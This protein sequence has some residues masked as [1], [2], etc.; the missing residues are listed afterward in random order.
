MTETIK[1]AL[2]GCGDRG[3]G[4]ASQALRTK[5]PVKLWAMA[6]LFPD[7]IEAKLETLSR[8]DQAAYDREGHQ[9]F[10]AQIDV[11]PERAALP[12]STPIG[13]PWS[14]AWML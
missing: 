8:G 11:P 12:A 9:G 1:I 13:R 4:A 3:A 10:P 6:D 7:R 5:G 2:I 14:P